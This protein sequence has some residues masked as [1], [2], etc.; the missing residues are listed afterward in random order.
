VIARYSPGCAALKALAGA[1][2]TRSRRRS[3]RPSGSATP[4]PRQARPRRQPRSSAYW[5]VAFAWRQ[6]GIRKA[7]LEATAAR[8]P[9]GAIRAEKVPRSE[10]L[11]VQQA[12]ATRKQDM[13]AG[14]QEL[15]ERSL[16]LRQLAGIE[17]GPTAIAIRTEAL[18]ATI[19]AV[20]PE[21]DGVVRAAFAH[22]AEL[23]AL[24]QS[25]HA[26][27]IAAAA[28]DNAARSRLDLEPLVA[29]WCRRDPVPR[30]ERADLTGYTL[31][32]GLTADHAIEQ[33]NRARRSGGQRA[34]CSRPRSPS[35]TL[36]PGCRARHA[37][38]SL[39]ARA[40]LASVALPGGLAEQNVAAGQAA[41][42]GSAVDNFRRAPPPGRARD[43]PDAPG[44]LGRRLPRRRRRS[45]R[46]QRRGPDP[47]PHRLP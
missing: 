45:R 7:S 40:A 46:P 12:I 37:P 47:L 10:L 15:Y 33:R 23:A 20:D 32:A 25:R 26:A 39:R 22:S 4:P 30:C 24:E 14:E 1:S 44:G 34:R 9:E 43:S 29:R 16:A 19:D 6:L 3:A 38:S 36:R 31:V 41:L 42:R 28:A 8:V 27:E 11:A 13:I 18:P 2:S 17:I 5:Q 35:A 21:I